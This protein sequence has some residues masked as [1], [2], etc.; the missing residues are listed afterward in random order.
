MLIIVA[1]IH[2]KNIF[3]KK[4]S[5]FTVFQ[6]CSHFSQQIASGQTVQSLIKIVCETLLSDTF[7]T[8]KFYSSLGKQY[9]QSLVNQLLYMYLVFKASSC[10]LRSCDNCQT[11]DI[12]RT[13]S[14]YARMSC[15]SLDYPD[16]LI[17]VQ[18][19]QHS[20]AQCPTSI[21][22]TTL[23]CTVVAITVSTMT[24]EADLG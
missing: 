9:Q 15:H 23:G 13:N 2:Y 22:F 11:S 8:L 1:T 19:I 4:I 16:T 12:F 14:Q 18:S 7:V 6:F 24:L 3:T 21:L 17:F 10:F 5:R 20:I